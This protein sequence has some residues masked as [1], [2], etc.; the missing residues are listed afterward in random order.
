MAAFRSRSWTAPHGHDQVRTDNGF[1]PS[2]LPHTEQSCDDGK[3]LLTFTKVRPYRAAFSSSN[4][5]NMP[6][7]A[8]C[9]DFASRVRAN[10]VTHK[11]STNTA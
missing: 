8:S 2:T 7:P 5:V 6:H 11:S 9:T 1:G 3:N 10:P 4:R